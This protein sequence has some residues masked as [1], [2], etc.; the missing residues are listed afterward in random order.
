VGLLGRVFQKKESEFGP[1]ESETGG[2]LSLPRTTRF[3]H[4][5]P[6]VD[7]AYGP[8][9]SVVAGEGGPTLFT[10]HFVIDV[11]ERDLWD[12]V[13]H[14]LSPIFPG[15]ISLSVMEAMKQS[16]SIIMKIQV[17]VDH[18]EFS[19]ALAGRSGHFHLRRTQVKVLMNP[20][21]KDHNP[22]FSWIE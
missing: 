13:K 8:G 17:P 2:S 19:N 22:T 9:A 20:F 21:D 14:K 12:T 15:G 4:Q 5:K 7:H 11:E 1:R 6:T 18:D 16:S 10:T 3:G